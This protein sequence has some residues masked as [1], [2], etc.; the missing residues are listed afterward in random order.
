MAF[1]KLMI[2]HYVGRYYFSLLADCQVRADF[3][4][5]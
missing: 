1:Q 5:N 4:F 3:G 2:D